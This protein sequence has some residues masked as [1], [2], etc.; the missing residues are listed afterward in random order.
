[1]ALSICEFDY[2]L[3]SFAPLLCMFE[4]PYNNLMNGMLGIIYVPFQHSLICTCHWWYQYNVNKNIAPVI[5]VKS[6][7]FYLMATI[8][9]KLEFKFDS[10][11]WFM[12][13]VW[14][15]TILQNMV[16][17]QQHLTKYSNQSGNFL[18]WQITLSSM[19]TFFNFRWHL[20]SFFKSGKSIQ[21]L[22]YCI[23]FEKK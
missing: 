1:M 8:L 14:Y 18:W 21:K 15:A 20:K 12:F 11:R 13:I 16:K 4:I 7:Q 23:I 19:K 2:L 9:P 3:E 6:G 22:R 17:V 10:L 5:V